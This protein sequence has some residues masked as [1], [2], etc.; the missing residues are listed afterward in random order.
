MSRH[1]DKSV[2]RVVFSRLLGLACFLLIVYLLNYLLPYIDNR[3]YSEAVNFLNDNVIL[4]IFM[5]VIYAAGEIFYALVF[6][7]NLP[8]PIINAV[9]SYFL[10]QFIFNLLLFVGKV[11]GEKAFRVFEG[12]RE[13]AYIIVFV[14]VLAA[15]YLGIFLRLAGG[16]R[17]AKK[18]RD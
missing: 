7:L 5:A 2:L 8:A 14:A 16:G 18:R 3:L 9:A 6:P 11:T 12:F 10:V 1:D 13:P 15:G 17:K 4:L